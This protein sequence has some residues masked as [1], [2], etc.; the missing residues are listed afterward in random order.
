MRQRFLQAIFVLG[1]LLGLSAPAR[2]DL[3]YDLSIGNSAISGFTGPYGSVVLHLDTTL[4][5][6]TLTFTA[7]D[8]FRLGDGGFVDANF[9]LGFTSFASCTQDNGGGTG[10]SIGTCSNGGSQNVDGFGVFSQTTDNSDGFMDSAISAVL[11]VNGAWTDENAVLAANAKGNLLA[12]HIFVCDVV[13]TDGSCLQSGGAVNTGYATNGPGRQYDVP[14]PQS[15]ALLGL[16]LVGLAVV[17]RR[18]NS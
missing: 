14:E 6:A 2:A 3:I 13:N 4:H 8:G 17:R 15:L 18:R 9:G 10:F 7:N 5:Q 16:G 1:A 12:A 11:T